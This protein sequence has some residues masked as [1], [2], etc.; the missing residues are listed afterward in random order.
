MSVIEDDQK[1]SSTSMESS[2]ATVESSS[3][4]D[5]GWFGSSLKDLSSL[6][7]S[8]KGCIPPAIDGIAGAIHRSV[9]NVAAE[10]SQMELDAEIHAREGREEEGESSG[11]DGDESSDDEKAA[12][13]PLPWEL[14]NEISGKHEEDEVLKGKIIALSVNEETFLGPH[15]TTC[16]KVSSESDSY[17]DASRVRLIRRLFKIDENLGSM[18]A[19]I[20]GRSDIKEIMFWRNYFHQCD[21]VK[22][23]HEL[24]AELIE[25]P[26]S[27]TA[28]GMSRPSTPPPND[29]HFEENMSPPKVKSVGDL[30]LVGCE[31]DD[32]DDLADEINRDSPLE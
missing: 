6:G 18:H 24:G 17:L 22:A 10:F 9:A 8:L 19:K 23:D 15:N 20:S 5:A 3:D 16:T 11:V 26:A 30:V 27:C 14:F 1:N 29:D 7:R 21:R 4:A 31:V 2:T 13:L 25:K 12:S 28:E 32:L